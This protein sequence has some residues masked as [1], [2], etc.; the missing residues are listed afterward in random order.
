MGVSMSVVPLTGNYA[1]SSAIA[2]FRF[3]TGSP[4][5]AWRICVMRFD[6][7][8]RRRTPPHAETKLRLNIA[9]RRDF[10]EARYLSQIVVSIV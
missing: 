4:I 8:M 10:A 6:G 1:T 9:G 7:P 2:A 3:Y 5:A